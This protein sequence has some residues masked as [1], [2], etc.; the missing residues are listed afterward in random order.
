MRGTETIRRRVTGSVAVNT[1]CLAAGSLSVGWL[2]GLSVSPVVQT[3]V[4]SILTFFLGIL[5]ALAG[6]GRPDAHEMDN[7]ENEEGRGKAASPTLQIR[8][9]RVRAPAILAQGIDL[10]PVAVVFIGLAIG[11]SAGVYARTNEFFGASPG[12]FAQRWN[13][14]GLTDEQVRRRL[15]DQLYPVTPATPPS[16][17]ARAGE[18]R[19]DGNEGAL[20]GAA[21]PERAAVLAAS[22]YSTR[23]E[24]CGLLADRHGVELRT[25]LAALG[26]EKVRSALAKCKNDEC[27]EAIKIILCH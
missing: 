19:T 14:V 22:L 12:R 9:I 23:A 3:V 27:G 5:G 18:K 10:R 25:R 15:F 7:S 17:A 2:I 4:G 13:G 24:T 21:S 16:V 8:E 11:A 26:D 20:A 1:L 6:I